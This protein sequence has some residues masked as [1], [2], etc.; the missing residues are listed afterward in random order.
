MVNLRCCVSSAMTRSFLHEAPPAAVETSRVETSATSR[1]QVRVTG[2]DTAVWSPEQKENVMNEAVEKATAGGSNNFRDVNAAAAASAANDGGLDVTEIA[3]QNNRENIT[4]TYT[5]TNTARTDDVKLDN[6]ETPAIHD[7]TIGADNLTGGPEDST[8]TISLRPSSHDESPPLEPSAPVC[9]E[10]ATSAMGP[11]LATCQGTADTQPD[12][13]GK[14]ATASKRP[15]INPG[16]ASMT[17]SVNEYLSIMK[18]S[19]FGF[20]STPDDIRS[21]KERA[22]KPS[23]SGDVSDCKVTS[24]ACSTPLHQ[25]EAPVN[26]ADAPLHQ[27][28]VPVHQAGATL[29]QTD[30]PFHQADSLNEKTVTSLEQS[31][32]T[33]TSPEQSEKT[34]TSPEHDEKAVTSRDVP[35]DEQVGSVHRLENTEP[36][37]AKKFSIENSLLSE[38]DVVS[39]NTS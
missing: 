27:A 37:V 5:I 22:L 18:S 35:D 13:D 21:G 8:V 30:A 31:E 36:Q 11:K 6:G 38:S 32:K 17:E 26:Q 33:V 24:S 20:W 19:V 25:A 1:R 39:F 15:L 2:V 29:Q 16:V 23:A 9:D 10:N 14:K 34:V 28:G 4:D 12:R 3:V 7:V